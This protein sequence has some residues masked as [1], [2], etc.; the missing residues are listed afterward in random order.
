MSNPILTEYP[1][2]SK[3]WHFNGQLHWTA[4]PAVEYPNGRKQWWL[5]DK[6][7]TEK[8]FNKIINAKVW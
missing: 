4:G 5:N 8:K 6:E 1:D 7:Y 3:K 2:G